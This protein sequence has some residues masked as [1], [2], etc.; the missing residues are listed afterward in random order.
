MASIIKKTIRGRPYYY[1]R[2]CQRVDGK[3]KIVWQKYLGRVEDIIAAL[4][5]PAPSAPK[6]TEAV[7]TE[8]GAVAALY[9]LAQRVSLVEHIDRH[10]PK[11]GTG[12][13]VGTYLLVAILNRCVAPCSKASIGEWFQG[14]VL[15]RL[16][17]V[18]SRQLSSQR[19]W[20]NMERVSGAAIKAIER[21]VVSQMVRDFDIDL[22]RVLF[23]ATNFF[24]FID[25]FNER[26][27]LAQRGKSKE[28]R[29]ALR[30][31]GLA[32]LVSADF[33][34]PLLHRTYPGNQHDAPTFSG[35]CTSLVAR[36]REL[37]D[38]A[39][40]ITLIFDK[41]N[42]S[43]DNLD[44]VAGSPYHFIGSLVPTQHR[45]LLEIPARRFH[46]LQADGLAGVSVH[47]LTRA[48]FGIERTV[49]VTYNDNLF[50]AQ[51][52]TLLREIAKRQQR[53]RELQLQLRRRQS[54]QIR[55]GKPPTVESVT[56]KIHSWLQA[57][58]MTELF[59]VNIGEH[60]GMVTLSYRFDHRAWQRLQKTLLGKT[61]L[62]TDNDDWSDAEIV[63]GYRAQHHV[64]SAFRQMKDPHHIAL[65]PQHHWTDQK[66]EVHVLCCVLALMLCALLRRELHQKGIE[67]SIPDLL[68]QLG[69]I[70]EVGVVYPRQGKRRTPTIQMTVSA[71]SNDQRTLYDT[72]DLG[73]YLAS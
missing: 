53:L 36:Y 5:T 34:V 56:K 21:D 9:D 12:P 17:D 4:T 45:D 33:Q 61:L 40:H 38:G 14:T 37:T 1:A 13:T 10:V 65:R 30:I 62:F 29:K 63:R 41:G 43:K 64:E 47:R 51:S 44:A 7:I 20:D 11:R 25:T 67:R 22:E 26:S 32:L 15:R 46:S 19:F 31:V 52:R 68:E 55:R 3:P 24:T 35:L 70:Q 18:E 72:L 57:R 58:H 49:L 59:A 23:D 50:V 69:K 8:L 60:E 66:V 2:E 54:G 27:T 42:N 16:I 48:V 71:M 28:G 6:P 73:R 39:E